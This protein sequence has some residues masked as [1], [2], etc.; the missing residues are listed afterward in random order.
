MKQ[1]ISITTLLLL[2]CTTPATSA[3]ADE[4]IDSEPTVEVKTKKVESAAE[5]E[6]K[7]KNSIRRL[8]RRLSDNGYY[9]GPIDGIMT[10]EL[11]KAA[12]GWL[13]DRL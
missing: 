10:P 6:E 3:P 1:L 13:R 4:S 5:A 9:A 11:R 7:R 2:L 8:Q 12:K